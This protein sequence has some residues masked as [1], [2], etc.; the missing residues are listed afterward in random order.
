MFLVKYMKETGSLPNP[1]PQS[2]LNSLLPGKAM[3]TPGNQTSSPTT[4][5]EPMSFLPS[6]EELQRRAEGALRSIQ[7]SIKDVTDVAVSKARETVSQDRYRF[8]EGGFDLDLTYITPTLIAMGAPSTGAEVAFRNDAEDVLRFFRRYHLDH[9]M[10]FNV[11]DVEDYDY[12]RFNNNVQYFGWE[13]HHSPPLDVLVNVVDALEQFLLEDPLNTAAVHCRAGKARTGVVI[14]CYFL[15]R[16][17]FDTA[18]EAINFFNMKRSISGQCLTI[19]SQIRMVKL[20]E[21][22][23]RSAHDPNNLISSSMVISP[24][25]IKLQKIIVHPVPKWDVQGNGVRPLIEVHGRESVMSYR[26]PCIYKTPTDRKFCAS[27]GAMVIPF[28]HYNYTLEGDV[29]IRFFHI[30]SVMNME[31]KRTPMFRVQFHTSYLTNNF[32]DLD[33]NGLDGNDP[34]DPNNFIHLIGDDRLSEN[35]KLRIMFTYE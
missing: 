33:F 29:L 13:D 26:S 11:N 24:P 35:T 1:L 22:V 3:P 4:N 16:G 7:S 27:D 12:A 9:F 19:P 17:V 20:Y 21:R 31:T 14:A 30:S 23:L 28:E 32:L 15:K 5:R 25:R 6:A 34:L 18:E 2:L 8:R 10:I